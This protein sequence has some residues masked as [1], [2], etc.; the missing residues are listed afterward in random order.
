MLQ[1]KYEYHFNFTTS[2]T[3]YL[4]T[5]VNTFDYMN[6]NGATKR[7]LIH[8]DIYSMLRPYKFSLHAALDHHAYS[9][10][11]GDYTLIFAEKKCSIV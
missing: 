10:Q 11:N 9:T 1:D 7:S 3:V 2:Y 4:N 8:L 6:D 5:I